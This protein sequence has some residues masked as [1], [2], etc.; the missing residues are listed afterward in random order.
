M[1][2]EKANYICLKCDIFYLISIKKRQ[3]SQQLD[4]SKLIQ[5]TT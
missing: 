3:K 4:L 2:H 5:M 1:N